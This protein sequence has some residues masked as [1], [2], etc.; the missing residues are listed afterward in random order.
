[1]DRSTTLD[2][3]SLNIQ[4]NLMMLFCRKVCKHIFF[5]VLDK[6]DCFLHLINKKNTKKKTVEPTKP[7]RERR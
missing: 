1:M 3:V 6:K 2:S 7:E 4:K 5:F